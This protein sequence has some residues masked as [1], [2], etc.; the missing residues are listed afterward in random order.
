VQFLDE[1]RKQRQ[2]H[3]ALEQERL[4]QQRLVE[5]GRRAERVATL[6]SEF[7]KAGD[8]EARGWATLALSLYPNE[9]TRL[10]T[11]S[12][13]QCN[14]ETAGAVRLALVGIGA[15]ALPELIRLNRIA[16]V[17][18]DSEDVKPD[19]TDTHRSEHL[20]LLQRTQS[21]IVQLLFHLP[22]G[23]VVEEDL[24]EI[25][26]SG[27]NLQGL[28]C[29]G[30][31]LRKCQLHG[32]LF[33]KA[34][35]RGAVF[36]GAFVEQ[37]VF[38]KTELERA[39]F[40]GAKGSVVAVKCCADGTLFDHA[41]LRGSQ[42]DGASLERCHFHGANLD[43][44]TLR[45]VQLHDSVFEHSHCNRIDATKVR[46]RRMQWKMSDLVAAQLNEGDLS[47]ST[48]EQCKMMGISAKNVVAH[49][50]RFLN[51]NLGG[52][53]FNG[54]KLN[55]AQFRGCILGGADFR[56]C[57]LDQAV[58]HKCKIETAKFDEGV[59]LSS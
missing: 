8:P 25:D 27:C 48:F 7:G 59:V 47:D 6:I 10:L 54:A 22:P 33:K 20:Q 37:A 34:S 38:L 16:R 31:R 1:R 53:H 9:T 23:V 49:S 28:R 51:C 44:A 57:E 56:G 50:A 21:V 39:D 45:G 46:A 42:F 14:E 24:S 30:L 17:F 40:T 15:P 32:T 11:M 58:F 4:E 36:R 5:Q 26:L 35:I 2:A 18:V 52:I 29:E 12:L 43:D 41:D 19:E 55:N 3:V 13:G